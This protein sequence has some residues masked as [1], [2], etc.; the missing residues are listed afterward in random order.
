MFDSMLAFQALD[1]SS[2]PAYGQQVLVDY[3]YNNS[4]IRFNFYSDN[5]L[6]DL[7]ID[8]VR[9]ELENAGKQLWL[10]IPEDMRVNTL[11]TLDA[12]LDP[13][14]RLWFLEMNSNPVVHPDLYRPILRSLLYADV[15]PI[16]EAGPPPAG[17][18]A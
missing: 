8:S 17:T 13:M 2:V 5:L 12:I 15:S 1:R 18:S 7:G 3:R 16:A 11:F 14:D 9:E 6:P 4:W 10:E